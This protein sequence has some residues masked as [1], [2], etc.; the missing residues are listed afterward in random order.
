MLT[1]SLVVS[2]HTN[3]PAATYQKGCGTSNPQPGHAWCFL[4]NSNRP[5][6]PAAPGT[7]WYFLSNSKQTGLPAAPGNAWYFLSSCSVASRPP[8]T[9]YERRCRPTSDEGPGPAQAAA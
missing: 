1:C 9:L 6:L 5:A 8:S 4:S 3:M 2:M 7:A